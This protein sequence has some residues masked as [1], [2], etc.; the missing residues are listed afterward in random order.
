[1]LNKIVIA[2]RLTKDPELR[3]T[4]SAKAVTTLTVA[5]ERDFKN[6]ADERETDFINVTVWGGAAEFIARSSGKG[7][8]VV[9]EGRLQLRKYED[10]DG[11]KRIAAE[12]VASNVYPME[13]K[14]GDLAAQ[15][16]EAPPSD[17][18]ATDL[19]FGGLSFEGIF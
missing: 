8:L 13:W 4:Q 14:K 2:G 17:A 16:S 3:Y 7:L 18:D 15:A 11:N 9:V 10:K 19:P 6:A 5:C 12:V 1:M